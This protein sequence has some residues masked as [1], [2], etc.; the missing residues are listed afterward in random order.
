MNTNIILKGLAILVG[1]F[2]ITTVIVFFLFPFIHSDLEYHAD[3]IHLELSDPDYDLSMIGPQAV[4]RLNN[5]ITELESELEIA[6]LIA[7]SRQARIDS[8][9]RENRNYISQLEKYR[10][11]EVIQA[12]IVSENNRIEEVTRSLLNLEEAEL[13]PILKSMT[14]D[15][16]TAIYKHAR[17]AQKEQLLRSLDPQR[18]ASLIKRIMS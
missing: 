14:E 8:L 18:A 17:A 9:T 10:T 2:L 5:R 3:A 11:S 16:L 12:Q 13:T 7:T 1:G 4:G 15:Q 6:R